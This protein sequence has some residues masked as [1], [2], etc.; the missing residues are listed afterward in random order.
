MSKK[1]IEEEI[2]E[3]LDIWTADHLTGFL[4]EIIAFFEVYDVEDESD[5]ILDA[6]GQEDERNVR[7]IRTVYLLSRIAEF[8]GGKLASMKV[9]F[10]NLY[11][12]MEKKRVVDV[13]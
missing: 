9:N 4:R 11:Q 10:K 8:Y 1:T 3:V 6:V 13:S 5:W 12:R 2:N 7:L